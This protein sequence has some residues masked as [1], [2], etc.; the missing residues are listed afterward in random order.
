MSSSQTQPFGPPALPFQQRGSWVGVGV[1][2]LLSSFG[3]SQTLLSLLQKYI[4]K[5]VTPLFDHFQK[6]TLNWTQIPDGL[7]DQ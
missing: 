4:Q 3:P 2:G 1:N 6:L 5:Q 7:M